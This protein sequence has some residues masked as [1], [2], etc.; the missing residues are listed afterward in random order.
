[1]PLNRTAGFRAAIEA[2]MANKL[3]SLLTTL[4]INFGVAAVITMLAIGKGTERQILDQLKLVGVN[5]ITVTPVIKQEEDKVDQEQ[6][7]GTE[8]EKFSPGL[9][10]LDA[11]GIRDVVPGVDRISPEIILNMNLIHGGIRRTARLVGVTPTF[12]DIRVL[13]EYR[14]RR[15]SYH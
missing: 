10:L 9:T 7:T 1:M 3:R 8:K 4:G 15:F 2:I 13:T 5:N 6:G 14:S 11:E 12:F